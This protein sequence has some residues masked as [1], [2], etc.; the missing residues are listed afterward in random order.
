MNTRAQP[1]SHDPTG[2]F[3]WSTRILVLGLAGI[4]FLTLYPFRFAVPSSVLTH[5]SPFL[6]GAS[7]KAKPLD[8]LLNVLLFVPFGFGLAARVKKIGAGRLATVILTWA[9]GALLSYVI[10]FLQLFVPGRSSGWDDVVTN[11]IGAFVGA[12]IF[13]ICG[14]ALLNLV[15]NFEKALDAFATKRNFAF[16]LVLYFGIWF[17]VSARLQK[18]ACLSNWKSNAILLVGN[19]SSDQLWSAWK[20]EVYDLEFWDHALPGRVAQQLTAPRNG[21]S[22]ASGVLADYAFPR[23]PPFADRQHLL[24]DLDWVSPK[25]TAAADPPGAAWNGTGW[26][27]T[28]LPVTALVVG[29]EKTRQ[30]SIRV[31]C[32]PSHIT[33]VSAAII[34]IAQPGGTTNMEIRQVG[35]SVGFWFRTPLTASRALLTWHVPKLFV[36]NQPRD[37]LFS[38]DGS[39]LSLAVDGRRIDS[40]YNLGPGPALALL[41]RAI[42]AVE[43]QGYRYIFYV[44]VFFP[45]GS[46]LALGWRE[47]PDRIVPRLP[48]ALAA[49]ILP[50]ILLELLL[51]HIGS[52][53]ISFENIGL[54][55]A[56]LGLGAF[57]I[58]LGEFAPEMGE[59]VSFQGPAR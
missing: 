4:L 13:Q 10:E 36:A 44:L 41:V 18:E 57:W 9:A 35:D 59:R 25:A 3:F 7:E 6:L 30:F 24:P 58:N 46:L 28:R 26:A 32:E 1:Y 56:A 42:N 23:S 50:P 2:A 16:T 19:S 29:I 11:S 47:N 33:G 54:A 39:K 17:A 34:S 5:G 53:S 40:A 15:R 37:L 8:I 22:P 31:R 52:Q 12:I 21:I 27:A 49:F 45:A 55:F 48:I 51:T 38:Y 14:V 43:L 20:G